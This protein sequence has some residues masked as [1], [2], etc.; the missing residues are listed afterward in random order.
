[1]PWAMTT[2]ERL[3]A[4]AVRL[5]D[6][7]IESFTE[8]S[9]RLEMPLLLKLVLERWNAELKAAKAEA[10]RMLE[11]ET[12]QRKAEE[13]EAKK[14]LELETTQRRAEEDAR[15]AEAAAAAAR[16]LKVAEAAKAHRKL[17]EKRAA[18]EAKRQDELKKAIDAAAVAA[19]RRQEKEAKALELAAVK[20]AKSSASHAESSNSQHKVNR[21]PEEE[22]IQLDVEPPAA[23]MPAA[24]EAGPQQAQQASEPAPGAS[25]NEVR[26][27]G[28]SRSRR[29]I[30]L[31]VSTVSSIAASRLE[32]SQAR[33]EKRQQSGPDEPGQASSG[34]LSS[35][36]NLVETS[37]MP[38]EQVTRRR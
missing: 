2:L 25:P 21:A 8:A 33:A 9:D 11:L 15:K 6:E 38:P 36:I 23:K 16:A 37:A 19:S 35:G 30:S 20:A 13:A 24:A 31:P 1:M 27:E 26:A 14:K 7:T 5:V 18:A 22:G 12:A 29:S 28:E 10:K 32:R 17:E 3:R 34:D 4:D